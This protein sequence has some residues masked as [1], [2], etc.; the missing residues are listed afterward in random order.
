M[1][2]SREKLFTPDAARK[3]NRLVVL[4][5]NGIHSGEI[6]G[7]DASFMMLREM[8][9]T[10]KL[11]SLLNNVVLLVVPIFNV[12]GHERFG[13]YNRINQ[14]GPKEMGWRTTSAKFEF[15]S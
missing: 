7:K 6:G 2:V 9:I 4:I 13:P 12:D 14:N 15:E 10:K 3:A 11:E 1:I 8:V 5:I